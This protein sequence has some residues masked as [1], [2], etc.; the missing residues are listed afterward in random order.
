MI[1]KGRSTVGVNYE[2]EEMEESERTKQ[3]ERVVGDG[4]IN[5]CL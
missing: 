4:K 5:I 2:M 1:G 3:K